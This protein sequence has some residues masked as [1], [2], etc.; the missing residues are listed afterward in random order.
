MALARIRKVRNTERSRPG[1]S[2]GII[3]AVRTGSILLVLTSHFFLTAPDL[4]LAGSGSP[5]FHQAASLFKSG[6]YGVTMFFVVSGFLITRVI[7]RQLGGLF[8][9]EARHFYARRCGRILPLLLLSLGVGALVRLFWRGGDV[10]RISDTFGQGAEVGTPLFWVSLLLFLFNWYR[11]FQPVHGFHWEVLWSLSIEEQFYLFYPLLLLRLRS[12]SKL[13]LVL[14]G[15]ILWG[16][17][18]RV[19]CFRHVNQAVYSSFGNFDAIAFGALLYVLSEEWGAFLRSHARVCWWLCAIGML[20]LAGGLFATNPYDNRNWGS[21]LV[22]GGLFLFLLGAMPLGLGNGRFLRWLSLPGRLSYGCYLLHPMVLFL[23][24][25]LL[26]GKDW[27]A[28]YGFFVGGVVATAW[29]SY[30]GF[31]A[32]M[33]QWFRR[34]FLALWPG[35][36]RVSL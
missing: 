7:A 9:F 17:L 18:Y 26:D 34:G 12:R 22:A 20:L 25:P 23:I 3:D 28:S 5:F 35:Q 30:H 6:R 29:I 19:L 1:E 21:T 16:W 27:V 15:F 31:E 32:P 14:A 33:N 24:W 10:P 2:I 11:A 13:L 36:K 8:S 4:Q